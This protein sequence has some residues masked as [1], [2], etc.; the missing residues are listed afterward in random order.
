MNG[1]ARTAL[2]ALVLNTPIDF[3]LDIRIIAR[4]AS[5]LLF[6]VTH[7]FG[8]YGQPKNY[9]PLLN[10]R[11]FRDALG[12][13]TSDAVVCEAAFEVLIKEAEQSSIG[14]QSF[15]EAAQRI[16]FTIVGLRSQRDNAVNQANAL[17]DIIVQLALE[18]REQ[19]ER[20]LAAQID[21][22]RQLRRQRKMDVAF[23]NSSTLQA[24]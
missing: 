13:L 3:P 16:D 15:Q 20:L 5:V 18:V 23:T 17:V 11:Y 22:T 12:P 4:R 2:T 21:L 6:Q 19:K 14:N 9:V 7:G 10:Y 24:R 1:S 8:Y